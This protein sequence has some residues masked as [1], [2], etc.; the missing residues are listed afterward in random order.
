MSLSILLLIKLVLC[1]LYSGSSFVKFQ[2]NN[3]THYEMRGESNYGIKTE[4]QIELSRFDP[5]LYRQRYQHVAEVL[6]KEC[7]RSVSVIH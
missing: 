1:S 7:V 2:I 6:D 5:P 4:G 3:M